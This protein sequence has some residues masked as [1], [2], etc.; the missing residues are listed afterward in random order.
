MYAN[1]ASV[2]PRSLSITSPLEKHCFFLH[3]HIYQYIQITR[4]KLAIY[5]NVNETLVTDSV[6]TAEMMFIDK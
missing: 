4:K 5:R 2:T 3:R 6:S 1:T